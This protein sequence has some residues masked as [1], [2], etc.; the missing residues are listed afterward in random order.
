LRIVRIRRL[1]PRPQETDLDTGPPDAH[2]GDLRDRPLDELFEVLFLELEQANRLRGLDLGPRREDGAREREHV[3]GVEGNLRH[4]RLDR[5]HAQAATR[6]RAT[7]DDGHTG[8]TSADESRQEWEPP[9]VDGRVPGRHRA[10]DLG[11]AA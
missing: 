8:Q 2:V 4:T 1:D 5:T 9:E 3:A 11:G 6:G 10:R 7:H